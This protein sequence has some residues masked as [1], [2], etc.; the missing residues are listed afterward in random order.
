M[1]LPVSDET[2]KHLMEKSTWA[3]GLF[4][5]L[6]IVVNSFVRL[7]IQLIAVV[8][9]L[10]ALVTSGPN[11]KLVDLGQS[12]SKFSYQI[13][14]FVTFNTDSRPYPFDEVWPVTDDVTRTKESTKDKKK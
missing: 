13:M 9:F 12:L 11:D 6:F 4:M 10:I 1:E 8:Q 14:L 3:R 5:V 7:A 2:K